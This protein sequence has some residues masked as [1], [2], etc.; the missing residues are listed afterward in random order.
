MCN[1]RYF[2]PDP[3]MNEVYKCTSTVAG[4]SRTR[5]GYRLHIFQSKRVLFVWIDL[6]I[7]IF[8][9]IQLCWPF[10]D[11]E[12]ENHGLIPLVC[13]Q[14][15]YSFFIRELLNKM[16]L[17]SHAEHGLNVFHSG[18]RCWR[19]FSIL[20]ISSSPERTKARKKKSRHLPGNPLWS[21]I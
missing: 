7:F 5:P 10:R 11:A 4:I 8:F 21:L 12:L 15:S 18:G 2:Q 3:L 6:K 19:R 9:S 14:P 16:R 1:S 20:V 17:T 13:S